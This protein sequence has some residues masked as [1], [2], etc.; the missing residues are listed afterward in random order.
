VG[1][2]EVVMLALYQEGLVA[3]VVFMSVETAWLEP[4]RGLLYISAD[5][6]TIRRLF[7]LRRSSDV[8]ASII[9]HLSNSLQVTSH[10]HNNN[11]F[12]NGTI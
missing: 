11:G 3:C 1:D 12:S 4:L 8:R 9:V 2:V 10:Y 5:R 7:G 6:G